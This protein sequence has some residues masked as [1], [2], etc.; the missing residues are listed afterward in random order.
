M[1]RKKKRSSRS[2]LLALLLPLLGGAAAGAGVALVR[3]RRGRLTAEPA[4]PGPAA[5]TPGPVSDDPVTERVD[6]EWTCQCGQAYRISG[7]GL[8]RVY[9]LPDASIADPVMDG[10][11]ANCGR[12]L[13]GEQPDAV[14]AS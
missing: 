11:C 4:V 2:G 12:A 5:S 3:R 8:H 7:E 14:E 6:Q 9:W 13:P 1:R 10:R